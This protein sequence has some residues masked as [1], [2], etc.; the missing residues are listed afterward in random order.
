MTES[1]E[2]S[3]I[4]EL[5]SSYV[6]SLLD[7]GDDRLKEFVAAHPEHARELVA[8]ARVARAVLAAFGAIHPDPARQEQSLHAVR[9][10]FDGREHTGLTGWWHRLRGET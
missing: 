5:L 7:D 6:D 3:V 9:A 8:L 2:Q 10:R 4:R 1:R